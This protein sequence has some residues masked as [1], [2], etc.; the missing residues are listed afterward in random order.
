MNTTLSLPV[1]EHPVL[2]A[3]GAG[4][5]HLE[6]WVISKVAVPLYTRFLSRHQ[7]RRLFIREGERIL[8]LLEDCNEYRLD[9]PVLVKRPLGIEDSSRAWS[10]AETAEHVIV[11]GNGIRNLIIQLS[12]GHRPSGKFSIPRVKPKG[13]LGTNAYKLLRQ[14]ID[15]FTRD[16]DSL[17]FS[18]RPTYP[19]PWFGE[20]NANQWYQYAALHLY[21]HRIQAERIEFGLLNQL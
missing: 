18:K 2:E 10:L 12:S 1:R 21:S 5:P 15:T 7:A 19:H 9:E 11:V 8:Y 13:G 6:S 17:R 16:L 14:H 4:L 3:P 20:L